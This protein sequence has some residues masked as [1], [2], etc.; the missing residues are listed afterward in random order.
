MWGDFPPKVKLKMNRK[1]ISLASAQQNRRFDC[2]SLH[3]GS[4]IGSGGATAVCEFAAHVRIL[5]HFRV[6]HL[7][8][9]EERVVHWV[10]QR[11]RHREPSSYKIRWNKP[12]TII[13]VVVIKRCMLHSI[14]PNGSKR[15]ITFALALPLAKTL[16]H[17]SPLS[18]PEQILN[19][20]CLPF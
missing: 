17:F 2:L 14:Q 20:I 8:D 13:V 1:K 5:K 15:A 18:S 10:R 9:D 19:R 7:Q 16:T 4:A 11:P 12:A 6:L 3:F